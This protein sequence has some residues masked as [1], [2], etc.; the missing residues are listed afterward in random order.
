MNASRQATGQVD[1]RAF[2]YDG[3]TTIHLTPGFG[4]SSGSAIN[5]FGAVAGFG[6]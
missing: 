6:P 2:L 3:T 1:G 5:A 4:G